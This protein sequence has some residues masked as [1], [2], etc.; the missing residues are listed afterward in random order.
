[1]T[2]YAPDPHAPGPG[3]R[4]RAA[5]GYGE[6]VQ[7][8]L[9][10]RYA[11]AAV[12]VD[13]DYRTLYFH[14]QTDD[15]LVHPPD[16]PTEDLLAMAR[17]G[18]RL[19]LRAVL[20]QAMS[21][22]KAATA[23]AE[24]KGREASRPVQVMVTPVEDTGPKLWLV[25]FAALPEPQPAAGPIPPVIE[26][27][28]VVRHLEDELVSVEKE[29]QNS[30]EELEAANQELKVS[31]EEALSMNEE[32]QSTNEE[33][34]TSKE[35]LQSLNE[36]LATV[37]LQLED[38]VVKLEDANNDLSNLLSSTHIATLFLDRNFYIRR[39]TPACTRLFNLIPTDVGRPIT[40]IA[41]PY[42]D[43]ELLRDARQVLE[44]LAPIEKEVGMEGGE[45]ALRRV[46]PYRTQEDRIEGV[47]VTYSDVTAL[48]RA[49][50]DT[51]RLATVVR[52]SNDAITV[53]DFDGRILTWNRGAETL[54]GYRE[55]EALTLKID[56]LV[57]EDA[58]PAQRELMA[59]IQRGEAVQSYETQRLTQDGRVIDISLTV[60]V[61]RDTAGNPTA[62][63]TTERDITAR[64][65]MAVATLF[66][67]KERYRV[68]LA[69][70][71]EGVITTDDQGRMTFLNPAAEQLTGWSHAEAQGLPLS[72]AFKLVE[73]T[74]RAPIEDPV[75]CCLHIDQF[76]EIEQ[77]PVLLNRHCEEL[78]IA[79]SAAPIRDNQGHTTG[80]VLVFRDVT[81]RR[82]LAQVVEHQ[83]THDPLTGLV[84]REEFE[85]RL[86]RMLQQAREYQRQHAICYIDLDQ[87]KIVNDTCGHI[88]GDALLRQ[89]S[90]LWQTRIRERDTLGR[91]G[92]DEFGVLLGECTLDRA[93][94]IANELL[95]SVRDFRFVWEDK[96]FAIGVSIGLAP[97][98]AT[99]LD[100]T[101]VLSAA[102]SAC[103]LAKEQG[104]NRVCVYQPGDRDLERRR[105]HMQ[106][107]GRL[108]DALAQER[109]L[110][111][112]QPIMLVEPD[113]TVG[114]H[115][116]IL[117]R[118]IGPEGQILLPGSF[119]P[120]AER[121]QQM[122]AIDRWVVRTALTA[123]ASTTHGSL[124]PCYSINVSG[125]SLSQ[126]EFLDFVLE[127]LD[128]V[129]V[130]PA[131]VCFE[132][133]ETAA[134][135]NLPAAM[136][137]IS[138]LKAKGCRFALDDFGSGLSSFTYLKNLPVDY[139]KISGS[140]V[141]DMIADPIDQAMV[142]SIHR[143]GHLMGKKTVAE[144]VESEAILE[145]IRAIGVDCAQGYLIG[146]PRLLGDG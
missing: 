111:Y 52:D 110:L 92:G 107:V 63:A 7:R 141:K 49:V 23:V 48:R 94:H 116:E 97:I 35:E 93:E 134:I 44:T 3:Q 41:G 50:E 130:A 84:N 45:W 104:R 25:T 46:L 133:T 9:L 39:F 20:H 57:P 120:A 13:R 75:E 146:E 18:L 14:G 43:T 123:L 21:E 99:S 26:E 83:A 90:T 1:M 34:E 27:A 102:D 15:Y 117:L 127:Q 71:G 87:F 65:R 11:P 126:G 69:S 103:Y 138:T 143:I 73:E 10:Q 32:L 17:E 101:S 105:G 66:Q 4:P 76:V 38:K 30:I 89:L 109:F 129:G 145:R 119:L 68:T 118:L 72:E 58:R 128:R 114:T 96:P 139:L 142:Q 59:R 40:D 95:E 37:N 124:T 42:A 88:A 19:K 135:A 67:E 24:V 78:S 77:H 80:A 28:A 121:Y 36:E 108:Q 61:L 8:I 100:I 81:E 74:T 22:E 144:W 113:A 56:A 98:T 137:F 6:R 70:I 54:Y 115:G 79:G 132:I 106:W 82:Q 91:L 85:R 29:L 62:V 2:G 53:F 122:P 51:R 64:K 60:S 12:L 55:A 140:F 5:Q 31:N 47:V 33:L 112:Y 136:R 16:A 125:Q 86:E 131:K